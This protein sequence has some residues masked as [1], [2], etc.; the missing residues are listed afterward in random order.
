MVKTPERLAFEADRL[1]MRLEARILIR[2][3]LNEL[4]EE[5]EQTHLAFNQR[6]QIP[7]VSLVLSDQVKIKAAA[8]KLLGSTQVIEAD[9]A[10]A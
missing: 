4:E 1:R 10:D 9:G 2:A 7:Q 5:L 8:Q 3:L 6:G